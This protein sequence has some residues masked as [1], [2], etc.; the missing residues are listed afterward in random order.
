MKKT[1]ILLLLFITLLISACAPSEEAVRL[2]NDVTVAVSLIPCEGMTVIGQNPQRVRA[3]EDVVFC[4]SLADGL[5][6]PVLPD[7]AVYDNGHITVKNVRQPMTVIVTGKSADVTEVISGTDSAVTT[8]EVVPPQPGTDTPEVPKG[9]FMIVYH[10]NG[11]VAHDMESGSR[12]TLSGDDKLTVFCDAE[13]WLCPNTL[14][15]QGFFTRDGY[16]L[17]GYTTQPDGGDRYGCG[18]N[19]VMPQSRYLEL[20][21]LWSRETPASDFSFTVSDGKAR[22]IAYRGDDDM[23]VIPSQYMGKPVTEIAAGA[24][25]GSKMSAVYLTRGLET[26]YNGAFSDCPNLTEVYLADSIVKIYDA[27]FKNCAQLSTLRLM[28]VRDPV[29]T[30][31]KHGTYAVKYELLYTSAGRRVMV[32]SGSNIAYGLDS[33]RLMRELDFE[34][35]AINFGF[36]YQ[37]PVRMQ[38]EILLAYAREG[39]ILV[40]TP[41]LT[42]PQFGANAA[43]G[44]MWQLFES[45]Y[46]AFA[47]VDIRNYTGIFDTLTA[48]NSTRAKSSPHTYDDHV[49]NVNIYGDYTI[50][51]APKGEDYCYASQTG[52]DFNKSLFLSAAYTKIMNRIYDGFTEKGCHVYMSF[53]SV[54]RNGLSE[55]SRKADYQAEWEAAIREKLHVT[56]ISSLSDYIYPGNYFFDSNYHLST[57]ATA[58]RTST[59]ARDIN[60]AWKNGNR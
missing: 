59:L 10:A 28:A 56:L 16:A 49:N 37:V 34:A 39:D 46:E 40:L 47:C 44:T 18:W 29:Y 35:T 36:H 12:V 14:A 26:V 4:V 55:R 27:A 13:F 1:L 38:E 3:G 11:G 57:E 42:A 58:L 7:G 17:T 15:D 43:Y 24:F 41:E 20:Y 19:V 6:E 54:N 9:K 31:N 50:E 48:F 2:P 30:T 52:L 53:A 23:V 60:A 22:V 32:M 51:R 5:S 8:A 25:K 45:C 33:V 21:A